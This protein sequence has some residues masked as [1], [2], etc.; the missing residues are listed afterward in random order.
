MENLTFFD[1]ASTTPC[2]EAASE[3]VAHFASLSFGNPSSSH[4]LG[5]E[6]ATAIRDARKFF[7]SQFGVPAQNVVFTGSGTEA[8]NL[9]I[10]GIAQP[11]IAQLTSERPARPPRVITSAIEHPAIM[12]TVQ[13][14]A[15][16]GFDIQIAPVT[17]SGQ[18]DEPAFQELITPETVLVSIMQLNNIMGAVLPVEHLA[19]LA[20]QK[21][22]HLV[23]HTDA[24][25]AFG[26]V[27]VPRS[28]S[29]VD[30]VSISAHK[31]NGPKGVGA[32]IVLN[33]D[34][35]K[36]RKDHPQLW[37]VI[38]GGGQE[39]GLRSGTQNAGLIAGFHC[40]AEIILKNREENQNHIQKLHQRFKSQLGKR[41]LTPKPIQWN[42]PEEG[43]VPNIVNLS[44]PGYPAAP[45]TKLLEER[46]C[47]VSTGSACASQK[48]SPEPVLAAMGHPHEIQASTLRISFSF[49]LKEKDVDHL[50]QSLEES[51]QLM[52]Q[53]LHPSKRSS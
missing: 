1:F 53:L 11:I 7:G 37:P 18:I 36:N 41:G 31:I 30:L 42:S 6:A 20:K 19:S 32:L 51:I 26:R 23:F 39:N 2:C 21:N 45:L 28:N 29:Q 34:L 12:A 10:Y 24:I 5:Q 15:R 33:T 49:C 38:H 27:D 40:A 8:D 13:S 9:A 43:V 47:L 16:F 52:D 14:L 3:K 35:L 50:V 4:A 22:P 17:P 48:G 25:Q 44:L 46:G